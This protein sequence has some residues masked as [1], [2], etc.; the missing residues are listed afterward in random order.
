MT[1]KPSEFSVPDPGA[2]LR[3]PRIGLLFSRL[4]QLSPETLQQAAAL[5]S[6]GDAA[7]ARALI[8]SRL[9]AETEASDGRL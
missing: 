3:D 1:D 2:L 9:P 5:A 7:G 6:A 8:L 4:Q